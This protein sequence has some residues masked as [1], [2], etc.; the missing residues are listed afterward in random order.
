MLGNKQK[1]A[2]EELDTLSKTVEQQTK[3]NTQVANALKAQE[4]KIQKQQAFLDKSS[5]E[6]KALQ[7]ALKE[8]LAIFKQFNKQT[9]AEL[10][11]LKTLKVEIK[12]NITSNFNQQ[13]TKSLKQIE[14]TVTI[15]TSKID[16]LSNK[17]KEFKEELKAAKATIHQFQAVAKTLEETDFKIKEHA[18][19]LQSSDQEKLKLLKRIDELESM[20]AKFKR[21]PRP[22]QRTRY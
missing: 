2:K 4:A 5:L 15:D 9:Q 10:H 21:G 1:K 19:A 17:L 22:P 12:E 6:N 13:L 16:E 8:E 20:M 14:N 11:N 18:K 7:A 3:E